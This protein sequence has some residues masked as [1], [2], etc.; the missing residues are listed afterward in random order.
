[1][2]SSKALDI[3]PIN[4]NRLMTIKSK[5]KA[6]NNIM[7][8]VLTVYKV[9]ESIFDKRNSSSSIIAKFRS[10][11]LNYKDF[12]DINRCNKQFNR[13]FFD[14]HCEIVSYRC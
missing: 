6:G 5:L 9:R 4:L 11:F 3:G 13:T 14:H 8:P 2:T 1:M 12:D 10:K 7:S